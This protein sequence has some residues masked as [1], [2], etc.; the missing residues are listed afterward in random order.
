MTFDPYHK[1]LGIP[2]KEQPPNH[3]RLLGI[4]LFESD[5]EV[6][7]AAADQRMAYLHRLSTGA[8]LALA[9]RLLNEV[10]AARVCLLVPD[11]KQA[12]DAV[13]R[14]RDAA[15]EDR[16]SDAPQSEI[17]KLHET[18]AHPSPA[19]ERGAARHRQAALARLGK[20]V[21]AISLQRRGVLFAGALIV[22]GI[23]TLIVGRGW[24]VSPS[25]TSS[26]NEP[27]NRSQPFA[28]SENDAPIQSEQAAGA[29]PARQRFIPTGPA[30]DRFDCTR[31]RT[32]AEA[33]AAQAS[34]AKYLG[35]NVVEKNSLGMD[36][37][38]IP[39]GKFLMGS[40]ESDK[41]AG[42]NE[43]PQ[44]EVTLTE[45]FY[46]GKTEVTQGQWVSLM[47]T[48]PW[49]SQASVR[50]GADYAASYVSAAD[51]DA[52]C[53][54]LSQKEG[55]QYRVLT[56][57]EW[58]FACR[59][60]TLT[61][62]HFGDDEA[63]LG[64][65]AWFEKNAREV[66]EDYIHEAGRKQPNP[67]GLFDM[68][69]NA[70][71]WCDDT[72]AYKP[73]GG[74]NPLVKA[75]FGTRACRGGGCVQGLGNAAVNCRS[76]A[77]TW[78]PLAARRSSVGFR[79]ARV[80]AEDGLSS[81]FAPLTI[82]AGI[83]RPKLPGGVQAAFLP[84]SSRGEAVWLRLTL[85]YGNET[86]LRGLGSAPALLPQLMLR[87][88]KLRTRQELDFAFRQLQAE[89]S[90][91]GTA[92]ELTFTIKTKRAN[93]PGALELLHQVLREP[94]LLNEELQTLKQERIDNL[95]GQ[96]NSNYPLALYATMR[97]LAPY[98]TYDPRY[99]PTITEEIERLRDVTQPAIKRLYDEFLGAQAG[100]LVIVGDF[101]ADQATN[102][103]LNILGGWTSAMP[104][105]P[106]RQRGNVNPTGHVDHI[107]VAQPYS[108]SVART[109]YPMQDNDPD[110]PFV[111]MG[112]LVL[113]ESAAYGD[114]PNRLADRLQKQEA[115]ASSV[116]AASIV[117][118]VDP[119]AE[120]TINA[121]SAHE[122]TESVRQAI[123]EVLMRLVQIGIDAVELQ[124]VRRIGLDRQQAILADGYSLAHVLANNLR[125]KRTM[126]Y[127]ADLER[128]IRAATAQQ[129]NDAL[130][131][132]IDPQKLVIVTAGDFTAKPATSPTP[133][134]AIPATPPSAK[135]QT[136]GPIRAGLQTADVRPQNWQYTLVNPGPRWADPTFDARTWRIGRSGFGTNTGRFA[137]GLKNNTQWRSTD[138]WMRKTVT[139][140]ADVRKAIVT[141][142]FYH[143]D[144]IEIYVN[145]T[146]EIFLNGWDTKYVTRM[147]Q[148]SALHAGENVIAVHAHNEALPSGV[149]VG[150]SWQSISD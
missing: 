57:A 110:F 64:T 74:E 89:V 79:V 139:L 10:S 105:E 134:P 2:P 28:Q 62:Y 54:N 55:K 47:G 22:T 33:Q 138:I 123:A 120:L 146:R 93:L 149:D 116:F 38:V 119:R 40:P 140:P 66:G 84:H 76:A 85:R 61:K 126:S 36:L 6:I 148:Q 133:S 112:I 16:P 121:F 88:V 70:W 9:Q 15:P 91:Y 99:I 108:F 128:S 43:K 68:H 71:E 21:R 109:V 96:L 8:H 5:P 20:G 150:F 51:A 87:G 144:N 117:S 114:S 81:D 4:V 24:L 17:A 141:W 92:G 102:A 49:Q 69:G 42:A 59:G 136:V 27:T 39:A 35:T 115:L 95:Q 107:Q 32:T 135:P 53:R 143:D 1:W 31:Q 52:F 104:F 26:S 45:P 145:G 60:G 124:S 3:Y 65:F 37:V 142:K 113:G 58:E 98:D 100:E 41:Q 72:Y 82:E 94:S 67:F 122:K 18:P 34:W 130:R 73:P 25:R 56:E 129:V 63:L 131:K 101:D 80:P 46:A 75:G 19:V 13:L 29:Q 50:D 77:R 103:F 125:A 127:Y 86:N 111:M 118:P 147:T 44:V 97:A 7:E 12:Y 30:P 106:L 23:L 132:H 78:V 14:E 83:K 90:G 137:Y 48:R 11:K